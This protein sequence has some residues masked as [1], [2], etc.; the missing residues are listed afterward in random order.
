MTPERA[1]VANTASSTPQN[2]APSPRARRW[3]RLAVA[4]KL[5][6]LEAD[7]ARGASHREWAEA[8]RVPRS[9]SQNWVNRKASIEGSAEL[10]AFLESPS[11]L[12]FLH[13]LVLSLFLVFT[14]MGPFGR[15]RIAFALELMG[16]APFVANSHGS[17]QELGVGLE[18]ALIAYEDQFRPAL[19]AQM[20]P[21]QITVC[22]DETF[23][24]RICLVAIEPSSNFILLEKYAEKRDAA[25]WT[26]ELSKGLE[27]LPVKVIQSTSDEGA[28][29]L[30]HVRKDLGA[31][32]SPDIFHCQHDVSKAT[33][34]ALAAQTRRAEEALEEAIAFKQTL[35]KNEQEWLASAT[36]GGPASPDFAPAFAKV[37][38]NRRSA[39]QALEAARARQER[40][41]KAIRGIGDDYHPVDLSTGALVQPEAI[42]KKLEERFDEAKAVALEAG[43]GE[44]HLKL[45]AKARKL[46]PALVKTLV[47]FGSQVTARIVS[48]GLSPPQRLAVEQYLVPLAYVDRAAAKARDAA[49]RE[50]L[51][52]LVARLRASPPA[53]A[54][55]LGL[56]PP[57]QLAIVHTVARECAAIFQRSSS[58]TEGRNGQLSLYHHGLHSLSDRKLRA[59]TV[60]HNY[61]IQREDG[62]TAAERFFGAKPPDLFDW[63]LARI[64]MPSRPRLGHLPAAA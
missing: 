30:G 59:L 61:F 21:K 57:E 20:A 51:R 62:T 44:Q 63:L 11:G 4:T 10:V 46:L 36:I 29:L 38:A 27:G 56:L 5:M 17:L 47:F 23:H 9:T 42:G 39:E 45:I 2:A 24:P 25:T 64:P 55:A 54:T 53:I 12:A 26:A 52:D 6:D 19:A 41:R 18:N 34:I 13:R 31:H 49:S 3:S 50:G 7:L 35:H 43:L 8:N 37:D 14:E 33:S 16:L 40:A 32:H 58:C 28:G 60:I 48:L 15:R 22:E 1:P